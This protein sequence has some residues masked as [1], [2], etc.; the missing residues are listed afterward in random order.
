MMKELELKNLSVTLSG[1]PIIR[2][3]S[4]KVPQG[5][6]GCLLGPSGCGK[7]TLLRTVAGFELPEKGRLLIGGA[8]VSGSGWA[9]VPERRRV[10][11]VFQ[12]FTLFPNLCVRDNIAFGLKG[13]P[14]SAREQRV[15]DLLRLVGLR[16]LSKVYPDQL[17]GGEQQRVALARA[18]APRPD[19]LLL[20]EPFSSMDA[21]LRE[22][23]LCEVRTILHQEGITAIFVT[24]NQFEAF[25]LAD[26]IG[27]MNEGCLL[28]WDSGYNL[29]HHP[30]CRFVADFVGQGVF[31]QGTVLDGRRIETTFGIISGRMAT[32]FKAGEVVDV[33]IRPDDIVPDKNASVRARV[34]DRVFQGAT[35]RYT[36]DLNGTRV[37]CLAPSHYHYEIDEAIPIRLDS[38]HLVAFRR[39]GR[40]D[41]G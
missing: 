20:D 27:V 19:I 11:M 37:L 4:F 23:L 3:A 25:A 5:R 17:S 34:V 41:P 12:D 28:Q 9:L 30:K 15:N 6:T 1:R 22:Q 7:T 8:E 21:E 33:L 13:S 29:Y 32:G 24:H 40:R 36:L 2:E 31:L 35:F 10:G 18:L 26:E 14:R 39:E 16:G 38:K